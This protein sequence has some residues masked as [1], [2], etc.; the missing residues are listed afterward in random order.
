MVVRRMKLKN[1]MKI[2][3]LMILIVSITF[4][5][6]TI[7]KAFGIRGGW[8]TR[9]IPFTAIITVTLIFSKKVDKVEFNDLGLGFFARNIP[10]TLIL[11]CSSCIPLFI[12]L[13]L[14]KTIELKKPFD[15]SILGFIPYYALVAFSEEFLYRGYIGKV[16]E[17]NRNITKAV[18]SA[19]AFSG[20][21]F[22]SPEFNLVNFVLIFIF[23]VIFMYMY[24]FVRN[25]W[26]LI[27]FHFGWDVL[28]DYI[29]FYQNVIICLISL[30]IITLALMI[31]SKRNLKANID[32]IE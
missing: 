29:P 19:L 21:H 22:I 23:G 11:L 20:F 31:I 2:T 6:A 18:I 28:S 3:I 24:V 32:Y 15:I 25:L 8:P 27:L 16:L 1:L 14:N 10:I 7:L 13:I 30:L 12:G 9:L 17:K 5:L 26:P 4:T